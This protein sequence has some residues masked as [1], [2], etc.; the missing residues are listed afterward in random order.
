MVRLTSY[1]NSCKSLS[2]FLSTKLNVISSIL[3]KVSKVT[4]LDYIHI[5]FQF[6]IISLV[7]KGYKTKSRKTVKIHHG[8][9]S[10]HPSTVF[11]VPFFPDLM[12]LWTLNVQYFVSFFIVIFKWLDMF[13]LPSIPM[14]PTHPLRF[15]SDASSVLY[16]IHVNFCFIYIFTRLVQSR[17]HLMVQLI[18]K[19]D[20]YEHKPQINCAEYYQCTL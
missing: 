5:F 12:I 14:N 6:K 10:L 11:C 3:F 9:C 7:P 16:F 4:F 13:F 15:T 18:P 2:S 17:L 19:G 8:L 20:N 1:T